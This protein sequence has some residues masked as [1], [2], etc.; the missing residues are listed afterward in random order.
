MTKLI[1]THFFC[2]S[3]ILRI[4]KMPSEEHPGKL[5]SA[6]ASVLQLIDSKT[7]SE[8]VCSRYITNS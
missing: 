8:R 5:P 1:H 4:I 2:P 7:T 3:P 6:P